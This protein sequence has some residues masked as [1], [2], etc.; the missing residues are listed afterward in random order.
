MD[1]QS[2]VPCWIMSHAKVAESMPAKLG[3]FDLVI[4]DEASQSNRWALPAVLR[5]TKILVVGD[6]RQVSPEGGFISAL[7]I[8][9]LRDRFL[10]DQAYQ[11]VLTPEKSLYDIASTVFAA[12]KVMLTEHFRCVQPIIT[13]SNKTFYENQ[14]QPLRVPKASERIDPPLVDIYVTDGQ[15][16]KRDTNKPEAEVIAAEIEAI[17]RD[18]KLQKRT[19][20]VV[21]LL[22]PEQAQYIDSFVRA[23]C[24]TAELLRRK[25][26]C[27]DARVFQG[28]ERDIMFLSMV[29]DSQNHHAL[30]GNMF[31]QRFNVAAS[32]ARD[33]MYLV[34]SVRLEEL[35]PADLRV[36]L[37]KHFSNPLKETRTTRT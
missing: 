27:G 21:S 15:R 20:G 19:L 17:L 11:A 12:Q 25:F 14:I 13:Y 28:S 3:A 36:T 29:A 37:L 30:S 8:Q 22:G 31:D 24:D 7:K 10:S 18:P 4:V 16:S 5:G 34:R 9:A 1:A 26:E 33:R 35:S 2:A 6:D 23:R 32:R